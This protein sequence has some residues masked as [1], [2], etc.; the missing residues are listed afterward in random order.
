MGQSATL[1]AAMPP[2]ETNV[3]FDPSK[4]VQVNHNGGWHDGVIAGHT[5][6]YLR[7][8]WFVEYQ[9][10]GLWVWG[11]FGDDEIRN[12][13]EPEWVPFTAETFPPLGQVEIRKRGHTQQRHTVASIHE[14][15]VFPVGVGLDTSRMCEIGQLYY[16]DLLAGYEMSLDGGKTWQPCGV[17]KS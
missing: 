10:S 2:Q 1:N 12:A 11:G 16:A 8:T 4:P 15:C 6:H 13:P 17:K 5:S 9:R 7:S 3:N 14:S